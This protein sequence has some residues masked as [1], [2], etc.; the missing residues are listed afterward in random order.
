MDNFEIKELSVANGD[1]SIHALVYVPHAASGKKRCPVI[2][3]AH[4][5]AGSCESADG[6]AREFARRGYIVCCF[7]FAGS[8]G[9]GEAPSAAVFAE[10]TELE[11]VYD[12]LVKQP[13]ADANNVFLM[14]EGLGGTVAALCAGNRAGV[15]KGLILLYPA[16]D[17][18]GEDAGFDFITASSAYRGPVIILH[19][20]ADDVV[21]SNYSLKAAKTYRHA[22][23]ELIAGAGHGF[24]GGQFKYAVRK[25]VDFLDEETDLAD[26][27]GLE[28]DLNLPSGM[29]TFGGMGL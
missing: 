3:F 21:K 7:D 22:D 26:E 11:A 14:G 18:S 28:G 2:I 8:E 10:Q 9:A 13:Y 16:F 5:V 29:G 24:S 6:Y 20:T 15:I 4:D 12:A 27:S 23:L 19:G 1:K 17:L 25:I